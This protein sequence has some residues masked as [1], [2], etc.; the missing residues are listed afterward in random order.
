MKDA[1]H[2]IIVNNLGA[3]LT[4]DAS[5]IVIGEE[6]VGNEYAKSLGQILLKND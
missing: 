1:L 5:T 6:I 3:T 4:Y 2:K